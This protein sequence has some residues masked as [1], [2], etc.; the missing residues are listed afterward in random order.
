[1]GLEE[2]RKI[3]ELQD[4]TFPDRVKEI[5]ESAASRSSTT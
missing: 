3:K 2:K 1:M 5:Q 4:K